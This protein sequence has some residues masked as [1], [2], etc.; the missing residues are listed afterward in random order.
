MNRLA[1]IGSG[2]L[3]QSIQHYAVSNGFDVVGFFD[4]FQKKEYVNGVRLLGKLSD[5]E[6]SFKNNLFDTLICAIGYNHLKA[7]QDIYNRFHNDCHIPFATIV[8][9][10]C[11]VDATAHIGEGSVLFPGAFV[12]K[13]V[14]LE[15]NVLLNVCVTIAHDSKVKAHTFI[16]PRVAIAGFSTIG[17]R[18]MI[19]INSTIID[20]III[21]DDIRL[22]GG[23]FSN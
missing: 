13:G 4:D 15:D 17:S 18:C 2:D 9:R 14:E 22:G 12:D 11:H 16:S 20:N 10:S 7:R 1:I 5:I 21:G 19:G 6:N 8:D 3:G 23:Y